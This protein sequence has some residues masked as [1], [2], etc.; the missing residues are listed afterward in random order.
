MCVYKVLQFNLFIMKN[1]LGS[2][3]SREFKVTGIEFLS[4]SDMQKVR[5]GTETDKPKTRP[6]EIIDWDI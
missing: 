4:V 2:F 1:L 6:K 3:K 5:G